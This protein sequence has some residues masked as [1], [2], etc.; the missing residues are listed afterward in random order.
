MQPLLIKKAMLQL[1]QSHGYQPISR[2]ISSCFLDFV[3]YVTTDL[4]TN[5]VVDSVYHPPQNNDLK[6]KKHLF[7]SLDSALTKFPYA[8]IVK[9][10]DFNNLN[11]GSLI[12]SF[13]LKQMVRKPTQGN[14]VIDKIYTTLSKYYTDA[15]ILP[16][17]GQ[18]DHSS[19]LLSPATQSLTSYSPV[20]ITKR[21]C[22]P[23]NRRSLSTALSKI[24]WTP[25][26]H[27]AAID[28]QFA[29]SSSTLSSVFD[30][31]LPLRT[32]KH[33]PKDKPWITAD[34]KNNISKRQKAWSTGNTYKYNFYRNKVRKLCKFTRKFFHN[35]K[36]LNTREPNPK[37]WWTN[38]KSISGLSKSEPLSSI[39]HN[40][41]FK[42]G[43]ELADLIA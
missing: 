41:E 34:V 5:V 17:I 3:R 10:G 19:V 15:M 9:L 18:S 14:N 36:I 26:Y 21:D 11:P 23:A 42:R 28:N 38:I 25:L 16:C 27:T 24:N 40:S 2:M 35:S 6:L 37:K 4:T 33:H 20:Y 29:L 1:L 43:S 8:A 7:Q 13:N 32:V 31:H 12:S 30:T 39:F 22:R